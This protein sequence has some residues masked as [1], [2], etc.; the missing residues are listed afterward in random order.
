MKKSQRQRKHERK[1]KNEAAKP[2]EGLAGFVMTGAKVFPCFHI[3]M[4][5]D[6]NIS[7][8]FSQPYPTPVQLTAGTICTIST[9]RGTYQGHLFQ[10]DRHPAG[11]FVRG[12]FDNVKVK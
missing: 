3:E 2:F 4:F 9:V 5:D 8:N 6:G 11:A 10:V 1:M 7:A 12:N